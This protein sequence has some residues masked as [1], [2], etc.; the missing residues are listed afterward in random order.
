MAILLLV[1]G[2]FLGLIGAVAQ[3][4]ILN[5]TFG[6][7][8]QTYFVL[9]WGV[10]LMISLIGWMFARMRPSTYRAAIASPRQS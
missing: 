5:G 8:V 1:A 2:S 4:V 3:M 9:G 10:P 7:A 6:Q